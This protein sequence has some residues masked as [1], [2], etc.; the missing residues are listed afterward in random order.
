M[1]EF[2]KKIGESCKNYKHQRLKKYWPP[3][4]YF[5]SKYVGAGKNAKL[6][7]MLYVRTT[8]LPK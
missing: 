2:C 4:N 8:K 5:H 1:L 3:K 7:T 6:D